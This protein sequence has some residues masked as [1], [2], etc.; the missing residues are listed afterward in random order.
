MVSVIL[1]LFTRQSLCH[2]VH[3]Y[4]LCRRHDTLNVRLS[5]IYTDMCCAIHQIMLSARIQP[6]FVDTSCY[7]RILCIRLDTYIHVSR[8]SMT[9]KDELDFRQVC[10]NS[11]NPTSSLTLGSVQH[12]PKEN[13]DGSSRSSLEDSQATS[14]AVP[15]PPPT[16][17][18][19]HGDD[20]IPHGHPLA[21]L[22]TQNDKYLCGLCVYVLRDPV[23]IECGHR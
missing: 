4:L 10:C 17:R 23:Q 16:P 15:S 21:V 1:Y 20:S 22:V 3:M 13:R 14:Q 8:V 12:P 11:E 7:K 6:S 9:S 19:G 18:Q 2:Y 5:W